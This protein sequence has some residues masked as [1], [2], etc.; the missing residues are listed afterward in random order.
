M[1]QGIA[2]LLGA[3]SSVK[4]DQLVKQVS[5]AS[6]ASVCERVA[7]HI[8]EMSLSEARG[9][10]RARAA[11]VVRRETRLAISRLSSNVDASQADNV[12]RAATERLVPVVIRRMSV[13]VPRSAALPMAA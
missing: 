1:I 6:I 11:R 3:V 4:T 10:V 5:E 2:K 8:E 7:Q 13:G 12:V 9:Y